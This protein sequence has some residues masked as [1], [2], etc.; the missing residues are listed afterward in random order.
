MVWSRY[1][2]PRVRGRSWSGRRESRRRMKQAHSGD[3]VVIP[4]GRYRERVELREGVTLRTQLPGTVTLISPDGGPA[5]IAR[6]MDSGGVEGVWI[7][8][9][10]EAPL[11]AGIEVVD[12]S[13]FVSHVKITGANIGIEVQGNSAPVITASQITN[14]L[15]AGILVSAG[16][17][18]R[19]ESNLIAA[20]GNG[21]PD[22][23]KPGVEV[24]DR[25]HPVLK[26]NAIVNNGAEPVWIHGRGYQP[27]D[28]EENFFGGSAGER[29]HP[30]H[31]RTT[32]S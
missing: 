12:A 19:I 8:G 2:Q 30:L 17:S 28:F 13:P 23:P 6:K 9:D 31:R 25:G 24:L 10:L 29:S 5:L 27:A 15:G 20:N 32:R 11:A 1:T 4:Q 21:Q 3:T 26:D 16:A 7:Q 22:G 18:P 14:N